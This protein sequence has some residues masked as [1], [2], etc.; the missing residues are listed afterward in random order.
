MGISCGKSLAPPPIKARNIFASV[1][2]LIP[3]KFA[4][5]REHLI[6]H[7][8]EQQ[9]SFNVDRRPLICA[10]GEGSFIEPYCRWF[11]A[12]VL[13]L[14]TGGRETSSLCVS[15][16]WN[17]R[18]TTGCTFVAANLDPKSGNWN[19]ETMGRSVDGLLDAS[20]IGQVCAW[21]QFRSIQFDVDHS[22]QGKTASL[23]IDPIL[24]KCSFSYIQV[25]FQH[26]KR[27]SRYF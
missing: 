17:F 1:E 23:S 11:A 10:T 20:V 5:S 16:Q 27:V 25:R 7:T 13:S 24:K 26:D 15:T 19:F 9:S 2:D 18:S 3:T 12:S 21:N 4:G 6:T 8:G 14:N 22:I